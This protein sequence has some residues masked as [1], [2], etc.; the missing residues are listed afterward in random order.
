MTV[1]M[2]GFNFKKPAYFLLVLIIFLAGFFVL[3]PFAKA[4]S[5]P[6]A[7]NYAPNFW[8]DSQEKYYPVNPLDFYFESGVEING[9]IAVNKYNQLSLEAKLRNMTV[10]YHILDYGNQWVYQ[11]WFFYVFNDYQKVIKNKHYG[12]W[13]AVFVFVDKESKQVIKVIGT[14]H[15]RKIFD[16][17]IIN[18]ENERIWTY[19]GNGSHANCIDEID[20][21]YCDYK[22]W[23]VFEKWDKNGRKIF[24]SDY[25]LKE[26]TFDFINSF[27]GIV[28]FERSS[29][30]GINLFELIKIKGKEFYISW[31][32]SPPTHAWAQSSY[33]N[34]EEIRP[35]SWEYAL[36]K[37]S[38]TKDKVVGFFN[39]LA[40][41]IGNLFKEPSY[42]QAGI[43]GSIIQPEQ[44]EQGLLVE[45]GLP[46]VNLIDSN[47]DNPLSPGPVAEK[48][49][50]QKSEEASPPPEMLP[51]VKRSEPKPINLEQEIEEELI[52]QAES[53]IKPPT[54][55]VGGGAPPAKTETKTESEPEP[56]SE[57]EATT[58]S[59]LPPKIIS[60][61]DGTLLSQVDDY[62]TSTIVVDINLIGTSTPNYSIFI[63]VNSTSTLP[64][65]LIPADNQGDWSQIITLEEGVNTIKVKAQDANNNESEERALFLI[66][67]TIPP[68][69]ITDLSASSGASRGTIDLSWTAPGDDESTG[70]S[71]EYII[72]YTTSSEITSANWDSAIDITN[73]PTPSLASTT[74]NL[75]I[76]D[77][78]T[79]QTY[80]WAIKS[81]DKASNI[82]EISNCASSS[83]L[84]RAENLVISEIQISS[85]SSV[86]DAS[87]D[88]IELYNPTDSTINLK[89]YRLVKRTKNGTEDT[90]IKVWQSDIWMPAHSYYLWANSGYTSLVMMPDATST[91]NISPNNSIAIRYG[92][93]DTGTIIDSL[94][95]G[96]CQNE[97]VEG[98]AVAALSDAWSLERKARATSTAELLAVNGSHHWLGNNWDS[99]NNSSD[100]ILQTNPNPQN[101]L[102][103]TEP[104]SSFA[105]LADT[106]WPMLQHDVQHTG[107][108]SYVGSATGTP[109]STPK[110]G[111]PVNLG[112]TNP[113]SPVIGLDGSI[114]I[115]AGNGDLYKITTFGSVSI[116]YDAGISGSMKMP[117][118]SS[119]GVIYV[120][121]NNYPYG[122]YLYA[123]TS[124]GQLIWKYLISADPSEPVIG[125][126]GTIYI[127]DDFYLHA[128]TP[129][130]EKIWWNAE[131]S[132]GR[133]IR[134]PVIDF[135]GVIYTVGKVSDCSG[136]KYVY[137]LNPK[138]GTFLWLDNPRGSYNTALSLDNQGTLFVGGSSGLYALNSSD[139][140]KKWDSPI[141]DIKY[142]IPAI[143][144]IGSNGI[145]Y[146]S[147]QDH[148]LHAI[149]S[150]GK[151]QWPYNMVNTQ[152]E[153]S[154]SPI[155]DAAGT[156]Y[157]GSNNKI[158][159]A[160]N[161]EGTVKW[162]AELSDKIQYGA[163]I[164]SDGTVYVVTVDGY[165]YA[166]GE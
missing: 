133:W 11:Y 65:Y 157:I 83:P 48:P 154:A 76:G 158:F 155:I 3:A 58:T 36:E 23:K 141:G 147:S 164:G 29:E 124:E 24:Y 104:R 5:P 91:D 108:S 54:F 136:C 41:Q 150:K 127:A 16:T 109:T 126:D 97:F 131:L 148:Q 18:P 166:F 129:N 90:N 99:D 40:A 132:N 143:G 72:R 22:R 110:L 107:L 128:L 144:S 53:P 152:D 115:G 71:T 111:W 39:G 82:S 35:I 6:P 105:G 118:L 160:I 95:W 93:K 162:Q 140:S 66:V 119:D 137:A 17:E 112:A 34:P 116:F 44:F 100:F 63:F 37:V 85:G 138:D 88:F 163:V 42:Q 10:F 94:G 139:G 81:K 159:Y 165:L 145:I 123:L 43:S 134:S 62:A 114:Y 125:P 56:E 80:Y 146:V 84:A 142:S 26:I 19:V 13:E 75:T 102:S 73:E 57:S 74:E 101:S 50:V 64:N 153:I 55:I 20:D 15:Q 27:K 32:G 106:A 149:D 121:Y 30:L 33:D 156:I 1:F 46:L 28:S 52:N 86:G 12:D 113:T 14:A 92:P 161:P 87:D 25:T 59:P 2:E 47:K 9:E 98:D 51:P 49:A 68:A 103:L 69:T 70:A 117:V 120:V 77:L 38:Q 135:S 31:G 151:E 7:I 60:P 96:E 67:D 78:E 45:Q 61:N 4:E 122:N 89:G 130:G 8:F 21:G 79:G